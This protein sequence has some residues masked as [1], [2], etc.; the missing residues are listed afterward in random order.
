MLK[1]RPKDLAAKDLKPGLRFRHQGV[2]VEILRAGE[3]V[4]D[5]FGQPL[6]R[7]WSRN[8]G[9]GQEG[10]VSLGPTGRLYSV[11]PLSAATTAKMRHHA[12]K[13]SPAALQRE[14]DEVLASP[15]SH[16]TIAKPRRTLSEE[17]L[18]ALQT[19]ASANGLQWKSK[20]NTAWSTGRYDDYPGT[21]A[22]GALQQVRNALGPSWL[23]SFSFK[24]PKTHSIQA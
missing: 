9:T 12:T 22:Y 11:E 4:Q 2:D 10:Y 20:L 19:F 17:Q 5:R 24:N 16:S 8:L 1:K 15:G 7:W 14:I 23:V 13:K 21:D 6:D 3:R 18:A